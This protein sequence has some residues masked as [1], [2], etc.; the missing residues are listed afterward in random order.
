MYNAI[1]NKM[2]CLLFIDDDEYPLAPTRQDNQQLIWRGQ[3]IIKTHLHHIQDADVT[4]GY[5]CGYISPIPHIEYNHQISEHDYQMY[6]D[7]LSN[8]ILRLGINKRKN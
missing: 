3:D 8:D 7:G 4:N 6:I 2:D 5:H 1:M